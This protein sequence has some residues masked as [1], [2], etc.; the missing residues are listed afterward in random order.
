MARMT[1][2]V[3]EAAA[4]IEQ[5]TTYST[6]NEMQEMESSSEA[7]LFSSNVEANKG[8]LAASEASEEPK[9]FATSIKSPMK[10]LRN[11]KGKH[12]PPIPAATPRDNDTCRVRLGI[13]AMD[14]KARSKPMAEILS[15]L[16]EDLFCVVFFGDSVLLNELAE[17]WPVCDVLVAFYSKGYP[18]QKAKE[19]VTLRKPFILNDLG[20][21]ELMQ[22]RRRV[23]DLLEASGI[24]VPRHV[25]LSRDSYVSTGS[26]DGNGSRDLEVKEF[27]DHIEVNGVSVHK[28]FVE[29]PINAEGE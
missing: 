9:V 21:Q 10:T 27:D 23:Y 20:M 5:V 16:D 1:T 24:D 4:L 15:R 29:K 12:L 13:C 28:P 19:Y 17:S 25:Y 11:V 22:D 8:A 3:L 7:E 6:T 14:K 2:G 26:G 18:L